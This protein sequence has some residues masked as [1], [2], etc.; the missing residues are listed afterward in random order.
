V[1][2]AIEECGKP[3]IAAVHGLALGGG[4]ET[5]LACHY[6]IAQADTRIALPE[7]RLG[8][9]ALSAT[10]RLPRLL[11]IVAAAE[12]LLSGERHAAREL[13]ALFDR[14]IEDP[15][16]DIATAGVAFAQEVLSAGAPLPR[17]RDRPL[18]DADPAAILAATRT[19]FERSALS[20]AQRGALDAL[21]AAVELREFDAGLA[22]ARLIYDRLVQ[23]P[24]ARAAREQFLAGRQTAANGTTA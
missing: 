21:A 13:P 8:I 19:R 17:V 1:Q 11:G 15:A 7:V 23:S 14:L 9:L 10:Q 6:R 3:V 12:L 16:S 24:E 4:L 20:L 5:A 18:P 22:Q 2:A